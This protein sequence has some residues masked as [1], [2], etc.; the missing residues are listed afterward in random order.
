[1]TPIYTKNRTIGLLGG[2]FNPAHGGH[3]HITLYALNRL[4]LDE[5]WWLVSPRNPLKAAESLASYEKRLQSAREVAKPYR[6][7]KVL[8]IE[9]RYSTKY[10]YETIDILK[11]QY[12][13]TR[14]VWLIG[15]DNLA[16]FH[17]WRR[18]RQILDAVPVV[19]FDRTPY[20]H[21]SLRSKAML[22]AKKFLLKNNQIGRF[23]RGP[24][25]AFIHLRRDPLSS[26]LLRKKLGKNAFLGHNED[27]DKG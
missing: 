18:W 6:R 15:A 17:R 8:D 16:Q 20:S 1:M 19:V 10:S 12:R 26:S 13:G 22:R 4:G 21:T 9:R 2:S 11:K 14:F 25:I 3:L 5:V 24:A 23:G 7:I 27:A